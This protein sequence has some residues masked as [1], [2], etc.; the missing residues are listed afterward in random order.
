[1]II[2]LW[3]EKFSQ[4]IAAHVVKAHYGNV[5]CRDVVMS[6][7]VGGVIYSPFNRGTPPVIAP[8]SAH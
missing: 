2:N 4:Q 6:R 3:G 7:E 5:R 1:M 8:S